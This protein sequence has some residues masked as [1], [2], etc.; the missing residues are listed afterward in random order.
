MPLYSVHF[1]SQGY[2]RQKDKTGHKAELKFNEGKFVRLV[3][4]K[5]HIEDDQNNNKT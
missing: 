4:K 5:N 1:T 3:N 2:N